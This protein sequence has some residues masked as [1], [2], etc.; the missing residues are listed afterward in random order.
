MRL[1]RSRE[2]QNLY[3]STS[4]FYGPAITKEVRHFKIMQFV[5]WVKSVEFVMRPPKDSLVVGLN[6]L[7]LYDQLGVP[8]LRSRQHRLR[9]NHPISFEGG[10][11]EPNSSDWLAA[12]NR[13][14]FRV[15]FEEIVPLA[16]VCFFNHSDPNKSTYMVHMSVN[17][18]SVWSG[19][20]PAGSEQ[21]IT[22][23]FLT[24]C[25]ALE[26]RLNRFT[27]NQE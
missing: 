17:E 15:D 13:L 9:C 16:A 26:P 6:K 20:L 27:V 2:D 10:E 12:E 23:L 4:I 3:I 8:L 24:G 21:P 18:R 14:L 25:P 19:Y 7:E 11:L 5:K 1:N 22:A